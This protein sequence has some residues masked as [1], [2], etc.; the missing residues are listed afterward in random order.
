MALLTDVGPKNMFA[1]SLRKA[2]FPP[3]WAEV[4]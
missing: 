2:I 1:C 4:V 3:A